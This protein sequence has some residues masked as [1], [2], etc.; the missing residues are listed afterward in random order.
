MRENTDEKIF[1]KK[2]KEENIKSLYTDLTPIDNLDGEQES[3]K[4]LHWALNNKQI[5][6]IALTGPYG[7]GKSSVINSYLKLH[8]ECKA[9]KISLATF[10]GYT[11]DKISELQRQEKY[12]EAKSL[13][14]ESEDE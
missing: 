12:D 7:S 3:I 10:D 4:A 13:L 9:I 8:K 14:K 11:W 6:N 2:T 5:K 1:L